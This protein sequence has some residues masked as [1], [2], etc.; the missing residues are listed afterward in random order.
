MMCQL[1]ACLL[2]QNIHHP[3]EKDKT[4]KDCESKNH[5]QCKSI[6][7]ATA[8]SSHQWSCK[9]DVQNFSI[10]TIVAVEEFALGL[11]AAAAEAEEKHDC[12]F[13]PWNFKQKLGC[14]TSSSNGNCQAQVGSSSSS[15]CSYH[16]EQTT[17]TFLSSSLQQSSPIR[18]SLVPAARRQ[19]KKRFILTAIS[20]TKVSCTSSK[21]REKDRILTAISNKQVPCTS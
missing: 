20:N 3:A 5:Q 17:S 8:G 4:N 10:V 7:A 12:T 1:L 11:A 19:T 21:E 9:K 16:I 15:S 14:G 6:Q 18:K 13:F 2:A